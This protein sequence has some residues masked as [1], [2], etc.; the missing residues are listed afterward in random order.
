VGLDG[1]HP[2][3]DPTAQAALE[4]GNTAYAAREYEEAL[5]RYRRAAEV[6]A[7]HPSPAL[8]IYM[9]ARAL[10]DSTAAAAARA[11]YEARLEGLPEDGK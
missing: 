1:T 5:S 4:E 9:A 6:D 10:G 8:G 3:I 11:D 7:R 2:T